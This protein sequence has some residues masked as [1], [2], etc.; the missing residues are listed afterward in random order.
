M[1]YKL[2]N[3]QGSKSKRLVALKNFGDVKAGDIG[4][5]IESEGDV[6]E[7]RRSI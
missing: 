2:I 3:E 6:K 4:G 7:L 5:L 1:K